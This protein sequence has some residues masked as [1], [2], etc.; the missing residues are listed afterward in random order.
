ML[1]KRFIKYFLKDHTAFEEL[2]LVLFVYIITYSYS[3]AIS[4][5]F[6]IRNR[7]Y[8]FLFN[9]HNRPSNIHFFLIMAS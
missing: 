7:A 6:K 4:I 1:A 2:Y 3:K 5:F 8:T 9:K